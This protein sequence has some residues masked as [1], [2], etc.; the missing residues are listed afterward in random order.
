MVMRELEWTRTTK[1]ARAVDGNVRY[2][3][4]MQVN[5]VWT[6]RMNGAPVGGQHMSFDAVVRYID[7][8]GKQNRMGFDRE[9]GELQ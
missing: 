5:G 8:G 3:A 4:R 2:F 6:V 7:W 1:T 9:T